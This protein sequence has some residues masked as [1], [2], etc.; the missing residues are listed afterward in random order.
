VL[1]GSTR[2]EKKQVWGEV[3]PTAFQI[4]EKKITVFMGKMCKLQLRGGK[5]SDSTHGNISLKFGRANAKKGMGGVWFWGCRG[6]CRE[7]F[8]NSDSRVV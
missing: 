2:E 5:A 1:G 8:K 4:G 6:E 7:S 3:V